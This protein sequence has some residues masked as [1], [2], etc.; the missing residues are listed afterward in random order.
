MERAVWEIHGDGFLCVRADS[1]ACYRQ[2]SLVPM[3][4]AKSREQR[5]GNSFQPSDAT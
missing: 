2:G 3:G 1:G 5:L 4:M